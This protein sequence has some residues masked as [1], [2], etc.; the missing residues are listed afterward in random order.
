MSRLAL[1]AAAGLLAFAPAG[2][3][4]EPASGGVLAIVHAR[5]E[6]LGPQGRV[7]DATVVV[8]G[9]KIVSVTAH[10]AAPSGAQVI[11]A[12]GRVVTP[13]FVAASTNL[14]VAEIDGVR[15]TRDDSAGGRLGADFDVAYG[16]NP[17][18]TLIPLARQGG[19]TRAVVTPV[20]GR[21]YGGDA[22]EAA[23]ADTAGAGD[24][25]SPSASLFAGQAAAVRLSADDPDPVFKT[26]AGMVADLGADAARTT[27]A[28]ASSLILLRE[29][30]DDARAYLGRR[31]AYE[32]GQSRT[33]DLSK[34]DLEALAP[35]I[36]GKTPLLVR[37]HRAADIR[38]VL[39]IAKAE[40]V[41][42]IIEGA[43]EGWIVAPELAASGTPVLIDTEADLPVEFD[44]LG[45]RLD[46]AA[47][48]K[49]AG[50]LVAI[51]GS[52][53][54]DNLRQARFN[55]G[56]A[57]ANGL[58]Y[59]DALAAL[60][61]NPAKIWGFSDHLGSLEAGKEADLVIWSGDPLETATYPE[62]VFIAGVAQP[63]R[64]RGL[65][66]RD[67][68]AKPDDGLPSAYH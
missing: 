41:R 24:G 59:G 21:G 16:V 30:L 37:V 6:T 10:G 38:Q 56:T 5:A 47:R 54:F 29:A 18:S 58:A 8:R 11:D 4:A 32:R 34:G 7:E 60:T 19:I 61:L 55:A 14:T 35:V 57:V 36:E 31:A 46:N 44:S 68:Y 63:Q 66:L 53:D 39:K 48:L 33:F 65:E 50:V 3:A 40:G 62:A 67:R 2:N 22:E 17:A 49:A 27:G 25:L 45:S 13:G 12:A 9:G 28:H 43:E 52:R 20:A 26:H 15:E 23:E 1:C 51:E 64:T 42:L